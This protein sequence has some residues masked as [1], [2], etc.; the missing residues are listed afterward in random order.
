MFDCCVI[1]CV[2]LSGIWNFLKV[3]SEGIKGLSQNFHLEFWSPWI[4]IHSS[5]NPRVKIIWLLQFKEM[6]MGL[7]MIWI[8][9][10]NISN[11][12]LYATQGFSWEKI[13]GLLQNIWNRVESDEE[14]LWISFGSLLESFFHFEFKIISI[15][16]N[17]IKRE[18]NT[19][20][21]NI[22]KKIWNGIMK[23]IDVI[24][25]FEI[26]C[27]SLHFGAFFQIFK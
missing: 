3:E 16:S 18:G 25:K 26:I 7:K 6:K 20:P 21:T 24:L 23:P 1:D 2:K 11:Q 13:I 15:Y 14:N 5:Q 17:K 9:F 8:P 12:K 10:E 19:T 22:R 27:I 4:Q